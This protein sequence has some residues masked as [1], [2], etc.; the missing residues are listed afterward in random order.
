M[1]KLVY[2]KRCE[3]LMV[4]KVYKRDKECMCSIKVIDDIY[5]DSKDIVKLVEV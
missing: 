2:V 5:Y 3:K 4:L 1:G